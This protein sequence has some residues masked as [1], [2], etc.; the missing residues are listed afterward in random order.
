M[1]GAVAKKDFETRGGGIYHFHPP[2]SRSRKYCNSESLWT[3]SNLLRLRVII[4]HFGVSRMTSIITLAHIANALQEHCF[5]YEGGYT[6]I[7]CE[8]HQDSVLATDKQALIR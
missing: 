3:R 2:L 1:D 6:L 4:A 5:K 7:S 8:W